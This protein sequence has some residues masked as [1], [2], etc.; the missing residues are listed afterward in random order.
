M[1]VQWSNLWLRARTALFFVGTVLLAL[2]WNEW[3]YAALILLVLFVG[4]YELEKIFMLIRSKNKSSALYLPQALFLASVSFIGSLIISLGYFDEIYA[5]WMIPLL[6]IPFAVELW[7]ESDQPIRNIAFQLFSFVYLTL[8]LVLLNFIAIDENGNYRSLL[9]IGIIL[10][11][12]ANDAAAYLVGSMI[13]KNKLFER[14]SPKK[15]REGSLGGVAGSIIAAMLI[16]LVFDI[17]TW[18]DWLVISII[19]SITA[20][21]GD[22]VQSLF[23]RSVKIK[24]SGTLFPGHGG[25]LDRFDAFLYAIPFVLIYVLLMM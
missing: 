13:G 11:V 9:V 1:A 3:S 21:I 19:L 7:S 8:P 25:V 17:Y 18:K 16:W 23:K 10:I 12:W 24:D 6:F 15:T 20:S 5:I 14:I 22:L 4:H 2:F